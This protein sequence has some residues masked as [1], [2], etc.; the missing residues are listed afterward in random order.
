MI[1]VFIWC[2]LLSMIIYRFI[3]VAVNDI[4]SLYFYV[5]VI[6]HRVCIPLYPIICQWTVRLLPLLA[7]VNSAAMSIRVHVYFPIMVFSRYMLRSGVT[8]S[9]GKSVFIFLSTLNIIFHSGC[10]NLHFHQQ[11][12]KVSFSPHPF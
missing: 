3:H 10:T 9:Y 7:V 6:S 5:W 11:C 12:R 2:T 1:F 8:E 4:I